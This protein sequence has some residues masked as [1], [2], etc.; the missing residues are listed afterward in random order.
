LEEIKDPLELRD[1]ATRLYENV[2]AKYRNTKGWLEEINYNSGVKQSCPLSPT[3]FDIYIDKLEECLEGSG[4][5][6]P[7]L[8]S[9]VII[10]LLYADDIVLMAMIPSDLDKHLRIL[11]YFYSNM[12]MTV[13][14]DKTKVVIVKSKKTTH[15]TF[16]YDNNNLAKVPSYKYFEINIHH[17]LN[18]NYNIEKMINR[19]WKSYYGI[20]NKCKLIDLCIWDKK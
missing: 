19:G 9:I 14:T 15:D 10:L 4:C 16:I 12:S 17:K 5:V 13:N 7:T 20:E 8:A 11:Q 2:I 1:V 6:G 3:L 18:W